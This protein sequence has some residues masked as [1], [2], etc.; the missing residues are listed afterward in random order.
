MGKFSTNQ[1]ESRCHMTCHR[2]PPFSRSHQRSPCCWLLP[3]SSSREG[4]REGVS[5]RGRMYQATAT[6][7]RV[8]THQTHQVISWGLKYLL[9][10][11]LA[12]LSDPT[13]QFK[14]TGLTNFLS[15]S[16]APSRH[17]QTTPNRPATNPFIISSQSKNIHPHFMWSFVFKQ[18]NVWSHWICIAGIMAVDC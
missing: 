6:D 4:E 5:L 3:Q 8:S 18:R 15:L 12:C 10:K 17:P 2:R 7:P 11:Y 9:G 1:D 16:D 14:D 13:S